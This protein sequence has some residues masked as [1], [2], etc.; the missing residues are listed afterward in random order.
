MIQLAW[1]WLRHQPHSAL[2]RQ[3]AEQPAC[4]TATLHQCGR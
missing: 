4:D 2:T 1:L 3:T